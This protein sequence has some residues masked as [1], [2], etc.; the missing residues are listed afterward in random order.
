MPTRVIVNVYGGVVQDVFSDGDAEV[1]VVDWDQDEMPSGYYP[2]DGLVE[3][4]GQVAA[5]TKRVPSDMPEDCDCA[6][7]IFAAGLRV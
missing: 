5:V 6:R 2:E 1:F 4:D 3:V 7:A